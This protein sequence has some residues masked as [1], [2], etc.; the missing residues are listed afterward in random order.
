MFEIGIALRDARAQRGLDLAQCEVRTRIR[1]KYLRAMEDER[2]ELLPGAA[3]VR[4]FLRAYGESLGLDGQVLVDEYTL[5]FEPRP[6]PAH[7]LP[8]VRRPAPP[9][10]IWPKGRSPRSSRRSEAQLLWLAIGGALAVALLVW[11]GADDGQ[12]TTPIPAA[13]SVPSVRAPAGPAARQTPAAGAPAGTPARVTLSATGVDGTNGSYLMV[14]RGGPGGP[15]LFEDTVPAG[16]TRTFSDGRR[17]WV[18]VGWTPGIA[19]KVGGRAAAT[20]IGTLNY[21][22]TREGLKPA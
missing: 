13:P 5:R 9:G 11:V 19:L 3:Y 14:R 6:E 17:L 8:A 12:R 2:F 16:S 10:R 18:R 4:G 20:G 15:I 21:L 7:E 22:V 1:A